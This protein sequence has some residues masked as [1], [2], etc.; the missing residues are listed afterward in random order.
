MP[1]SSNN[2][3]KTRQKKRNGSGNESA[4][5]SGE[6]DLN[7][8][9]YEALTRLADSLAQLDERRDPLPTVASSTSPSS[10]SPTAHDPPQSPVGGRNEGNE[11]GGKNSAENN[12]T[13]HVASLKIQPK[14]E[15]TSGKTSTTEDI[16][17]GNS[18]D[19]ALSETENI[20]STPLPL[21]H[22]RVL[23]TEVEAAYKLLN[24]GAEYIHA[25]STKYALVGKVDS[26]EGG[27]L[28][29]ELR[30]GA[31]LIGTG[32]LLL[33]SPTSGASRSLRHYV[34]QSSRAV[35]ASVLSLIQSFEDGSA[36]KGVTFVDVK[37]TTSNEKKI[38]DNPNNVAAQKTGAVWSACE[39]L[40]RSLPKGNR[41]AMRRE[42]MV[43]VRDCKESIEEFE[44]IIELGPKLDSV[45]VG[46]GDGSN[47]RFVHEFQVDEQYSEREIG[48]AKAA[49]NVMKC[50]KNVL[51]LALKACECV[52]EKIS[53]VPSTEKK[54][55]AS[56]GN[57]HSAQNEVE[58][59]EQNEDMLQWISNLHELAR[60]V[61]EGV[62]DFG[63][64]LYPPID[65]T[66]SNEGGCLKEDATSRHNGLVIPNLGTSKVGRCL[67]HQLNRLADC[68][69]YIYDGTLSGSRE[70]IQSCMSGEVTELTVKM[71]KAIQVRG[72]EVEQSIMSTA[73]FR[74]YSTI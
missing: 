49:V 62:T 14:E 57:E 51:G 42:L 67:Q 32:T 43:W 58:K 6:V 39:S 37:N 9:V 41:A 46:G 30:K 44:E 60:E 64:L 3:K 73:S 63:I 7:A 15:A 26:K 1:P 71:T 5:S 53:E 47:D 27:N 28:A 72:T 61:G 12:I 48:V 21:S 11:G 34:K 35:I 22:W 25:T 29:V 2:K 33:F 52:G 40:Q 45:S 4:S 38:H 54:I 56:D 36:V 23:T 55:T 65:L 20:F 13:E 70:S 18:N 59:K 74:K 68:V 8:E 50:S 66:E 31:E 10:T 19:S 24:D 16:K 69:M 17:H